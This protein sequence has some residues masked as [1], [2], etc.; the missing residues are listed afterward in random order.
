MKAIIIKLTEHLKNETIQ[1]NLR[2]IFRDILTGTT[3]MSLLAA[4]ATWLYT[5]FNMLVWFVSPFMIALSLL[6]FLWGHYS[7][8]SAINKIT[9]SGKRMNSLWVMSFVLLFQVSIIYSVIRIISNQ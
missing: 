5:E 3:L 8:Q 1:D 9:P 7:I 6:I 4:S 2:N